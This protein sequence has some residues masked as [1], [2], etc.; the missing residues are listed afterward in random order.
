MDY[1][2]DQR[3]CECRDESD[4]NLLEDYLKWFCEEKSI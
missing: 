3:S 2:L 1:E 4:K